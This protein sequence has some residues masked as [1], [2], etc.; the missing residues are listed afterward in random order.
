MD[1]TI[2]EINIVIIRGDII[3]YIIMTEN[4]SYREK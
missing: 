2:L 1:R 3:P 4:K